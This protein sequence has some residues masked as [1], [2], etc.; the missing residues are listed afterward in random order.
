MGKVEGGEWM[1]DSFTTFHFPLSTFRLVFPV[2]FLDL[3]LR[4]F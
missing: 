4:L 1:N 3:Y 2:E